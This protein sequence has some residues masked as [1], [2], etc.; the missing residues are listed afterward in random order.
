MADDSLVT[1]GL[2]AEHTQNPPHKIMEK[3]P[4]QLSPN[5]KCTPCG[6]KWFTRVL[7]PK[8]CPNCKRQIRYQ[9]KKVANNKD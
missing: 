8:Q 6:Y 5:M 3:L 4:K 1:T 2:H 7:L 9:N